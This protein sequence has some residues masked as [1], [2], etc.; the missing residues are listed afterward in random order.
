MSDI[1]VSICVAFLLFATMV[2]GIAGIGFFLSWLFE[3]SKKLG[4]S[5]C[6]L[7]WAAIMFFSILQIME[8]R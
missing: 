5:V 2:S 1:I 4:W 6:A 3:K 8:M 7:A